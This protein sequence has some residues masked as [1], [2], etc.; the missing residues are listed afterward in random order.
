[1][2]LLAQE[3]A[4]AIPQNALDDD[5][6]CNS[7]AECTKWRI[8]ESFCCA[9][10]NNMSL[11]KRQMHIAVHLESYK[12]IKRRLCRGQA[13]ASWVVLVAHVSKFTFSP[14]QGIWLS[15]RPEEEPTFDG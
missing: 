14:S 10:K 15:R 3:E 9:K 2:E 8:E 12:I 11:T 13:L 7:G 5:P 1:M 4:Q 6:T